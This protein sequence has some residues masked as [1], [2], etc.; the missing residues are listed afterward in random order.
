MSPLNQFRYLVLAAQRDGNRLLA[1]A[2]RPL[3]VTPAQAEVLTVLAG[4][5]ELSLQALGERLV[6]ETGS[7]SRLAAA[8]VAAGW[9]QRR[10]AP[11]DARR[12]V[13]SLTPAGTGQAA[14]VAAVE[15]EFLAELE[16]L[17][18]DAPLAAFNE[19]LWRLVAHLPSGKALRLRLQEE[20]VTP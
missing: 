3:G 10:T 18:V 13:L 8:M 20:A 4:G 15:H 12:I 6:C 14:Q 16:A 5:Q 19:T 2:L 11:E 1:E 7:P 17:L 9:L